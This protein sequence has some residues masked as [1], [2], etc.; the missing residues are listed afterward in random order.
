MKNILFLKE[1]IY[2]NLFRCNYGR[3]EKSFQNFFLHF[4][5]LHS[6]LNI[7]KKKIT[8]IADVISNLRTP[9]NVVR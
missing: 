3:N 1:A 6:I 4:L 8:L 7:F 5:N 2:F 9:K